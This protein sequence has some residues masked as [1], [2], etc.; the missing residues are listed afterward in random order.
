MSDKRNP[1]WPATSLFG[2]LAFCLVGPSAAT[3]RPAVPLPPQ[4]KQVSADRYVSPLRYRQT[5]QWLKNRWSVQGEQVVFRTI[6]DLP[7]V[8]AAHAKPK[9]LKAFI[10]GANVSQI[11]SQVQIFLIR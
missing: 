11:G 7:G 10:R 8:V 4:V 9:A 2:L 6:V 3:P 5:L 1:S